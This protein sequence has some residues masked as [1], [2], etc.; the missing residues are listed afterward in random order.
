M[1][2]NMTIQDDLFFLRQVSNRLKLF[3]QVD[4]YKFGFRCWYCGDSEKNEHLTRGSIYPGAQ[5]LRY[6]CFNCGKQT[7]FSSFLKEFDPVI[8]KDYIRHKFQNRDESKEMVLEK[9]I[10][11]NLDL[12]KLFKLEK[13]FPAS[14]SPKAV[15]YL[16]S[17]FISDLRDIY[18][19]NDASEVIQKY[20]P[21]T[22]RIE[23]FSGREAILFPLMTLERAVIGCQLRF[24]EGDFR[25]LTLKFHDDFDKIYL[26]PDFDPNG[27]IW[28]TEGIFDARMLPN[29]VANLDASLS[30]ISSRTQLPKNQFILVHDNEPRNKEVMKEMN[31]SIE[32]GY[33]V[34]FWPSWAKEYGKDLN[35]I[36]KT[37]EQA[38]SRLVARKETRVFSGLKA[39]LEFRKFTEI[40]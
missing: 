25:Y 8:H 28:V 17:R 30:R 13:V 5:N 19:T 11:E 16:R 2:K 32:N 33:Q 26:P 10:P 12:P 35:D 15:I 29:G 36:R 9:T 24:L 7:T 40:G 18:F 21:E 14:V 31:R 23:K 22:K 6:G 1:I 34:F 38:F 37:S 3:K 4:K 27:Q 39:R 20:R